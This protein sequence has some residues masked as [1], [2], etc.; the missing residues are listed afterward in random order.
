MIETM[1]LTRRFGAVTAV[2]NLHLTVHPGEIYGFLGPNGAGKTTTIRMLVGLLRPS[3]G[4]AVIAGHDIQQKPL[5]VKRAVGYL[6]Q[7]P[8]MYERLTGREFLRF[9]GGLYGLDDAICDERG[10]ELLALLELTEKAEQLIEGYSGGMRHKL[11]L[12]AALLHRPQVLVLDEPLAGLDPYSARRV[13]DLLHE[14]AGQGTTVF[15][16]THTLEIAER[17]C[18]RVGILQQGSLIAEGTMAELRQMAQSTAESTLEELFLQLTG[19]TAVADVAEM[20]DK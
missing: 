9:V 1:G 4:T 17:V 7:S 16:S 20:L 18:D 6:A 5:A 13:K 10:A 12:C 11:G 15:F 14:L 3:G 19:G 2:S 8:P